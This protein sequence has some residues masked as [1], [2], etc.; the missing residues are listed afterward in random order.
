MNGLPAE[1]WPISRATAKA[2]QRRGTWKVLTQRMVPASISG[3]SANCCC[4][5]KEAGTRIAGTKEDGKT[6]I[7]A[8][9]V[10]FRSICV[11]YVM[12]SGIT[13]FSEHSVRWRCRDLIMF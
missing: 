9:Q 6:A 4:S 12:V 8:R 13:C 7:T 11:L 5:C 2:F 3:H 1:E 10:F